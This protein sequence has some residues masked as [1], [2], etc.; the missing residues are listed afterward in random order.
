[1]ANI[2]IIVGLGFAGIDPVGMLLL[3]GGLAKGFDK[4]KALI[5]TL[6]VFLGTS[7]L[8]TVLSAIF[9]NRLSYVIENL[10]SSLFKLPDSLWVVIYI[11]TIF[12]LV[13]LGLKRLRAIEKTAQD[14]AAKGGEKGL[15]G[16]IDI[17]IV[18]ALIDPTFI[19]VLALSGRQHL[20]LAFM[21]NLIWVVLSQLPLFLLTLTILTNKHLAFTKWFNK[22][23]AKHR[24]P[25]RNMVTGLVFLATFV[26]C[27][28]LITYLI[29][30]TWLIN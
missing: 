10:L 20:I 29:T 28:D 16:M 19:A 9:G 24:Q 30:G 22:L 14:K 15:W 27:S 5:F 23:V 6:G 13:I 2:L 26:L 25:V 17:M 12:F 11:F 4:K 7:L 18:T 21:S 1:M 8:G 3:L